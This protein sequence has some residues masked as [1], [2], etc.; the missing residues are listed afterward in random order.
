MVP[1]KDVVVVTGTQGQYDSMPKTNFD[2][3]SNPWQCTHH[4]R[5]NEDNGDDPCD[6]HSRFA[7]AAVTENLHD[8]IHEPT[9]TSQQIVESC[10]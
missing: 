8:V 1:L 10:T 6:E 2:S 9:I 7:D 5:Y 4:G 3:L